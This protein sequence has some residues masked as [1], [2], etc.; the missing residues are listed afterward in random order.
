MTPDKQ[1]VQE[2][3]KIIKARYDEPE[4]MTLLS[5]AT[6]YLDGSIFMSEDEIEKILKDN[7]FK[8]AEGGFYH[9]RVNG[10]LEYLASALSRIPKQDA[11]T[12]PAEQ[13]SR[14]EL[15]KLYHEASTEVIYARGE[16]NKYRT[17]LEK[18]IEVH[19]IET[20]SRNLLI[21]SACDIAKQALGEE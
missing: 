12:H 11:H 19:K 10:T 2:A 5:L 4:I 16:I 18:I 7:C 3:I 14:E 21:E 6:S 8:K 9:W 13:G 17:A 1:K 15:L 20:A